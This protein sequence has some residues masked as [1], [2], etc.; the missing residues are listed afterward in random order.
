[1]YS[2]HRF[3]CPA[4]LLLSPPVF[5]PTFV[6]SWLINS[7]SSLSLELC[8]LRL[9]TRAAVLVFPQAVAGIKPFQVLSLAPSIARALAV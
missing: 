4:A 3:M 9:L 8:Y 1:M 2:Q 5:P 6:T 7:Y